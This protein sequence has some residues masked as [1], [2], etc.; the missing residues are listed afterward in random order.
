MTEKPRDTEAALIEMREAADTLNRWAR[1]YY[2]L[3]NPSVS[4]ERYDALY[5][6]LV[7]LEKTTGV[8]LE[9]SPT[10]RVGGEPLKAFERY[11][12]LKRLYSL[13]LSLIHISILFSPSTT[14][15][16]IRSYFLIVW[17]ASS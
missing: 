5:D 8:V 13:D 16:E 6:R 12:H 14:G 17:D 9:D 4:D 11:R 3:D 15:S 10:R 2:V 1:E 7:R